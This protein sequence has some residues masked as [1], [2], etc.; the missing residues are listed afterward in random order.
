MACHACEQR[1]VEMR[2]M[3]EASTAWVQNPTGPSIPIILERL[4][5]EAMERGELDR[6]VARPGT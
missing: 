6:V 5:R 4:R 1:R 2:L 3:V